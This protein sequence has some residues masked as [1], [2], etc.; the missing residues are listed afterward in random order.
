MK[1]SRPRFV[2]EAWKT[3][4]EPWKLVVSVGGRTRFAT[5]LM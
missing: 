1:R 5:W 3:F 4:A 2:S